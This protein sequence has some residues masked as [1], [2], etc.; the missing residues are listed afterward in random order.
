MNRQNGSENLDIE[1][2]MN[3]IVKNKG[4]IKSRSFRASMM[5]PYDTD[6]FTQAAYCVAMKVI[7]DF[8]GDQENFE[9][10]FWRDF[11]SELK[12]MTGRSVPM[13]VCG[14]ETG[15]SSRMFSHGI[16]LENEQD[17]IEGDAGVQDTV[18]TMAPRQ[19]EVWQALLNP[20]CCTSRDVTG[21]T[22]RAAR[23]AKCMGIQHVYVGGERYQQ[24]RVV[25]EVA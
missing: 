8:P 19:M 6:D 24:V 5:S 25:R 7:E 17:E 2:A 14:E 23:A 11:W 10:H 9:K 18:Q 4:S 20:G 1:Y 13:Y 3:W 21:A 12:E 22:H 16:E 15:D